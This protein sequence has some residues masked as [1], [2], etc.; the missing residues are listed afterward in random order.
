MTETITPANSDA[1]VSL[2]PRRVCPGIAADATELIGNTPLVRLSRFSAGITRRSRRQVGSV[3]TWLLGQG[4]YRGFNDQGGRTAG[5]D[6]AG[7]DHH[8]GANQWQHRN[9]S[10]VGRGRERLPVDLDH[11]R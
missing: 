9:R 5:T 6:R 10:G 8:R 4:S 1:D 2:H 7:E 11:A 3:H